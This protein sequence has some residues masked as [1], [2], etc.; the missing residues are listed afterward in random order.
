[1]LASRVDQLFCVKKEIN[2]TFKEGA[3]QAGGE[4]LSLAGRGTQGRGVAD[5]VV[6]VQRLDSISEV[7][8][9]LNDS[10]KERVCGH[11]R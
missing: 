11:E 8:P 1:M 10:V 3:A 7:F 6:L 9:I 5:K 2:L 4:S